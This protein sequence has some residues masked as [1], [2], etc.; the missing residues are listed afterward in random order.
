VQNPYADLNDEV[1]LRND[2]AA[3]SELGCPHFAGIFALGASVELMQTIGIANIEKRALELNRLLTSRLSEAGW[4]VLSPIHNEKARSAETLV[5]ADNPGRLVAA[6]TA[7]NIL[8][9]EKPR[10]IR[11]ATDFFNN[12]DD[13]ERLIA[14]LKRYSAG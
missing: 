8:V 1:H 10:G 12:Q 2:V 11:V 3:R 5:A 9:T 14:G 13:V 6:L 4:N 7:Q